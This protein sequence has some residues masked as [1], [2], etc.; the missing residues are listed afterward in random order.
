MELSDTLDREESKLLMT[1]EERRQYG[2]KTKGTKEHTIWDQRK[3]HTKP[4]PH[5]D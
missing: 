1:D 3:L 5:P 2:R 4:V